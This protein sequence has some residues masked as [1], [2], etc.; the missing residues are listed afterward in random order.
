MTAADAVTAPRRRDPEGRRRAILAAAVEIIVEEGGPALTHRAVAARAGVALGSTT[1]YFDSIDELREAALQSLADEID[2][3][4]VVLERELLPLT[5]APE[6]CARY[7]R[8][9]LL[10][11]R[12]VRA[13]LALVMAGTD[14]PA[15]R[16]LAL[17]WPDHLR[18]ILARHIG[19]ERALAVVAYLD[20]ITVHAALSEA[21]VAEE[22]I[23][24][25]IRTLMAMPVAQ[26]A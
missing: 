3:D 1:Q 15:L 13:A 9:F 4:L 23:V 21:P 2:A 16:A 26:E 25:A 18:A 17:R 5:T 7:M 19:A 20:G 10:D 24:S 14:D 11:P 12:Q 6:R 8:E 22:T